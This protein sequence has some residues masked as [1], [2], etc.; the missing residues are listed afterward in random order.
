MVSEDLDEVTEPAKRLSA[1]DRAR[2]EGRGGTWLGCEERQEAR[3][4]RER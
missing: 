4:A 3:V 1:E 2:A